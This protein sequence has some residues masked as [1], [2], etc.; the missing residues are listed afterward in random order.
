M[1]LPNKITDQE[2]VI[3]IQKEEKFAFRELFNKYAPRLFKFAYSYLK[4]KE[5]AEELIQNVFL[6][7]WLKRNTID[8]SRNI[9][10]FIYTI[11]VNEI[12]DLIRKRRIERVFQSHASLNQTGFEFQTWNSVLRNELKNNLFH[13]VN[14]LPEQQQK[15]FNLSRM[16]GFTN[17]E[18]AEKMNL[19]K[20]TVENHLYRAIIFIKQSIKNQALVIFFIT[21]STFF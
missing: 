12:Y 11:T 10:A 9:K 16:E 3:Q 1:N 2:L 4:N 5:D 6:T 14:R 18:I 13:I 19:S 17:D 20:R 8:I 21:F 7:I 15:V